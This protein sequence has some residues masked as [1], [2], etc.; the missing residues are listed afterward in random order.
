MAENAYEVIPQEH[1]EMLLSDPTPQRR[2]QFDQVYGPGRANQV[3]GENTPAVQRAEERR[4]NEQPPEVGF[5]GNLYRGTSAIGYGVQEAVSETTDFVYEP[6][7]RFDIWA[8]QVLEDMGLP[9]RI[10]FGDGEGIRFGTLEESANDR[11]FLL[12]G[13]VGQQGDTLDFNLVDAPD[14]VAS[15]LVAGFVQFG[16]GFAGVQKFTGLTALRGAFINGAIADAVVFDP[17]DPNL[18]AMLSEWGVD[19]PLFTEAMAIDPEDPEFLNRLRNAGEGAIIGG[20]MEGIGYAIRARA[21]RNAG[22]QADAEELE[23]LVEEALGDLDRAIREEA[24]NIT[25]EVRETIE[26]ANELTAGAD[27]LDLEMARRADEGRVDG[28]DQIPTEEPPIRPEEA[29]GQLD[30]GDTPTP[31]REVPPEGSRAPERG[32]VWATPNEV[33]RIRLDANLNNRPAQIN[34][35]DTSFKSPR[36]Y[37]DFEEF[38]TARSARR[39][40]LEDQYRAAG[41]GNRVSQQQTMMASISRVRQMAKVLGEDPRKLYERLRTANN[42]D[43]AGLHAEIQAQTELVLEM[44]RELFSLKE[45]FDAM[46]R[47]EEVDF[48]KYGVKNGDEL[49]AAYLH[50]SEVVMNADALVDANR[51]SIARTMRAMQYARR[52]NKAARNEMRRLISEAGSLDGRTLS[53]AIDIGKERGKSASESVRTY[54]DKI[55]ET[56]DI[57]NG[58]R[59]NFLLSGPGTQEVNFISN[60]INGIVIP[61]EQA[62]GGVATGNRAAVRHAARQVAG[63]MA[64]WMDFIQTLKT[65]GLYGDYKSIYDN[66]PT[67]KAF[68]ENDAQLDRFH[69][70]DE[71]R[72]GLTMENVPG[73]QVI[74]FPSRVLMTMDELFKQSQ[75]R[76]VIYAD[77][78]AEADAKGLRGQARTDY[79]RQYMAESYENGS[80]VRADGTEIRPDALLQ[81]RRSTFT[82]PL[83]GDLSKFLQAAAVKSP[84]IRFVIPFVRTPL[85]ILS[86]TVQHMPVAGVVSK[87]WQA[88]YAAGGMRRAQAVGRQVVGTGLFAAAWMLAANGHVTGAGPSDPRVRKAW[89]SEYSPYSFRFENEDGTVTYQSFARYEPLSNVFAI[90]ADAQYIMTDEYNEREDVSIFRALFT[91]IVDNT[92][93]KTFTQGIYDTATV[94]VGRPQEQDRAINNVLASFI[95]NV[96]NQ[97]NGDDVLRETPRL[98]DAIYARTWMY[99]RVDPQ[100]NLIGEPIVRPMAK[101]DP[102]GLTR[103]DTREP[104]PVMQQI[105]QLGLATDSVAGAPSYRI[106]GPSEIDLRDVPYEG[107]EYQSLYDAWFERTGTIEIEG[108]TLREEL[109]RVIQSREY[110]TAPPGAPGV[111]TTRGTKGYILRRIIRAYRDAARAD[112]PQ[113]RELI[114][115]ERQG[116]GELL[117]QQSRSLRDLNRELFPSMPRGTP[118]VSRPAGSYYETLFGNQE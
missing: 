33:E 35:R 78:M 72:L 59:I 17:N 67:L 93:N 97:T 95:P 34:A 63:R 42:G 73:H 75:Y 80:A 46:V 105:L 116:R 36:T 70:K 1:I 7:E 92:I 12:G 4:A 16:A 14:T 94:F 88:D 37:G 99:D 117:L 25:D 111:S 57:I 6:L 89:L 82:E 2:V 52:G 76:G 114:A 60:L 29:Q 28:P 20:I 81:A 13:Q 9:S 118:G 91:S 58:V 83:T 103:F 45:G 115:A 50:T 104:D 18:T 53:R 3:M 8:S 112:I 61:L 62:I 39:A 96:L 68:W 5:I 98:I 40:V 85:N 15:S 23:Q 27:E 84:I 38:L 26:M 90:M 101:Y 113:L 108:R 54:S 30:L 66:S 55:R 100:R 49:E 109:E 65:A 41:V 21:A 87:R 107:N 22:R 19:I 10:R 31:T 11:D 110:I 48:A 32:P 44:E 69:S 74:T 47:G 51:S 79:V 56:A 24:Q 71:E 86:Q 43:M 64:G 102:L 106:E 77:A